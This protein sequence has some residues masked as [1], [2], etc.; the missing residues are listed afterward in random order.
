MLSDINQVFRET[1]NIILWMFNEKKVPLYS[2]E[3][4][5]GMDSENGLLNI[6]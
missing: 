2:A 3:R 5:P 4:I 1:Y 6:I